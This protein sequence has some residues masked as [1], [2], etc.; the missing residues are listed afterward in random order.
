MV[1]ALLAILSFINIESNIEF[2]Q[3]TGGNQSGNS[4]NN[5]NEL[6][7]DITSDDNP[8]NIGIDISEGLLSLIGGTGTPSPLISRNAPEMC[9]DVLY[10]SRAN[11]TPTELWS[12]NNRDNQRFSWQP[13][14]E[15]RIYGDMCLDV[16]DGFDGDR[17]IIWNCYGGP[18]QRWTATAA[19]EIRGNNGKCVDVSGAGRN[20]G[21][22]LILWPCTGGLNQ[23]WDNSS[24]PA[25][26]PTPTPTPTGIPIYPGQSIQ[27][28][29]NANPAGTAFVLKPGTHWQQRVI[30]K[31]GN[32][33]VGESGAVLDGQ[34]VTSY[35]F[36]KGPAPYPSNV[37]IRGLKITN[38][39]P[40]TQT[41]TVDA[42][43]HAP[44]EGTTGWIIDG[45]EVSYN[46]EYGIRIGNSTRVINN[47][48]HHNK[49]LNI[50]GTGNNTVIEGNEIAYGNYLNSFNTNFEAGG[51]KFAATDGLVLRNNYVHDNQGVGIHVDG[52]NIN[53][54]IEQNRVIN[55]ASEGIA[56]EISY[57]TR[58]LNNTV[59]GNGWTD[60]RNRYSYL[61]N[62]GIGIHASP[63]VE[64]AGNT[65][66]GNYAGIVAI[67]QDRNSD[68]ANY[69]PHVVQNFYV[70]D[71]IITQN[72]L[73][74]TLNEL[75]V[76]AGIATDTGDL[77][78]FTSQNNRFVNNTYYMGV[79]PR[80]FAWMNGTRTEFDWR[81]YGLDVGGIFNR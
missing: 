72:N 53:T 65:V 43:G 33:F 29:V 2:A 55:N 73:P 81:G 45:N 28:A 67:Q 22:D 39:N 54:L 30:P 5:S 71:N 41:A 4:G 27:T 9:I 24:A 42:G 8:L 60:P 20:N 77:R 11:G 1:L 75:S 47:N 76:G 7:Q 18:N 69:G 15:I 26:T 74:R 61:W 36:S 37:T 79:N 31:S 16:A 57:A 34:G 23:K 52:N 59:T 35:A 49:R 13:N 70:H 51:T 80:P 40:P 32:A 17:I 46:N 62:A 58:I 19:G 78:I 48:S 56:I 25:P 68:L 12:C 63:N 14:G 21:T 6:T 3:E 50:A 38:Y 10:N 66:S 64:V 44:S